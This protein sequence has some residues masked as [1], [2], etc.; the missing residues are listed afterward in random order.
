[1]LNEFAHVARRKPGFSWEELYRFL[2]TIRDLL[3]V[4]PL[5][6]DIH[7]RGLQLAERYG[8][9]VYDAM[10]TAAALASDT[11]LSE[12]MQDGLAIRGLAISNPLRTG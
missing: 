11:L 7:E 9:S 5:T 12:D 8:L 4:V 10:I 2:S 6:T 3:S 1:M